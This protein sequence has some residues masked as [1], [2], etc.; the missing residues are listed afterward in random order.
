MEELTMYELKLATGKVVRWPGA[1][2]TDAAVRYVDAHRDAVVVATRPADQHGLY[3]LG[4][5]TIIG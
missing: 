4:G 2:E 1:D 3:V 5:A